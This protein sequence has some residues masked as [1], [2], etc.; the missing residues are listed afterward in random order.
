MTWP[1]VDKGR[2]RKGEKGKRRKGEKG[3]WRPGDK[4]TRGK[5]IRF[6]LVRAEDNIFLPFVCILQFC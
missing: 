4:G 2:R 3:T 6:I 5:R 1:V